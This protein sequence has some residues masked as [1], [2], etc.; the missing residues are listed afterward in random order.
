MNGGVRGALADTFV[1]LQTPVKLVRGAVWASSPAWVRTLRAGFVALFHGRSRSRTSAAPGR[2]TAAAIGVL[3]LLAVAWRWA[4]SAAPSQNAGDT[5]HHNGE[6]GQ[7]HGRRQHTERGV[8]ARHDLSGLGPRAYYWEVTSA[9]LETRPA[10]RGFRE[11]YGYAHVAGDEDTDRDVDL[12][13]E[14]VM[15]VHNT[16]STGLWTLYQHTSFAGRSSNFGGT[17][18]GVRLSRRPPPVDARLSPQCWMGGTTLLAED[19]GSEAGPAA[20]F[21]GSIFK[22]MAIRQHRQGMGASP[23]QRVWL[24][25]PDS[26]VLPARWLHELLQLAVRGTFGGQDDAFQ[27]DLAAV[28]LF[29]N[30]Y[31]S[32]THCQQVC[33]ERAILPGAEQALVFSPEHAHLVRREVLGACNIGMPTTTTGVP[34]TFLVARSDETPETININTVLSMVQEH[35]LAVAALPPTRSDQAQLCSLAR[36]YDR[37]DIVLAVDGALLALVIAMQPGSVVIGLV[38]RSR[39]WPLY[40][41]LADHAGLQFLEWPHENERARQLNLTE[42]SR[43]ISYAYKIYRAP[44]GPLSWCMQRPSISDNQANFHEMNRIL[45]I[46]PDDAVQAQDVW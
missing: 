14:V 34:F 5:A 46:V 17:I 6:D 45:C 3:V 39:Y 22:T 11:A 21:L 44:D 40:K 38:H 33:F 42:A 13:D 4:L 19:V 43:Y 12:P 15:T 18:R 36:A 31:L 8:T 10:Q 37:A 35:G 25:T 24:V 9:C 16:D 41:I 29:S 20:R 32:R 30:A 27:M 7:E 2:S 23:F 1:S 28:P 26:P